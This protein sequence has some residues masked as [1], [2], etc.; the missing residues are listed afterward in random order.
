MG[1]VAQEVTTRS[2]MSL[3]RRLKSILGIGVSEYDAF[4]YRAISITIWL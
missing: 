4:N 1:S 3:Q 2:I